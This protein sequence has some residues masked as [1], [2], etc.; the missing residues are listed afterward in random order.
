MRAANRI[1]RITTTG[2]VTTYPVPTAASD[3]T[4]IA[5][6]WDGAMWFTGPDADAIGRVTTRRHDHRVPAADGRRV[7]VLDRGGA[8]RRRVVHRGQ[9]E[10]DR[11]AGRPARAGRHDRPHDP[12]DSPV[13]GERR[14]AGRGDRGR[15]SAAPTKRRL[16]PRDLRRHGA[17]RRGRRHVAPGPTGSRC[18]HPTAR[19]TAPRPRP[20]TSRSPTLAGSIASGSQTRRASGPR[21]SSAS[22]RSRPR[23]PSDVVA[24]GFPVSRSR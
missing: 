3:P 12:I 7:A 5:A 16:R 19:A 13:D 4:A 14:R 10:R 8:R 22:A 1:G 6:G 18:T 17:R 24:A 15:T 20:G 9:R 2:N 23:K 21:S 11:A